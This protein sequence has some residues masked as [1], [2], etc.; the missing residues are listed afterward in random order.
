MS[1]EKT[2]SLAEALTGLSQNRIQALSL[3]QIKTINKTPKVLSSCE[4]HARSIT[5]LAVLPNDQVVSGS[6]DKTLKVW[7]PVTGR[8]LAT[9][10]GHT[11]WVKC[12]AVL[13]NGQVVS[14]SSDNTLKVWDPNTGVCL[15][16]LKGH[17]ESVSCIGI[18]PNGQVVSGSDDGTL[19]IWEPNTG[20]CLTTLKGHTSSVQQIAISPNGQVVSG[21]DDGTLK[22]WEPLT[23]DRV[24]ELKA[25]T[26]TTER[27]SVSCVAVLPTGQI[28]GCLYD[29]PRSE[30]WVFESAMKFVQAKK[31]PKEFPKPHTLRVW[32]PLT[33]NCITK[34]IEH[35]VFCI[36]ILPTGQIVTGSGANIQIW[37]SSTGTC[38]TTLSGHT[39]NVRCIGILPNGQVVSGSED[40]TSKVWDLTTGTCLTTLTRHTKA[41]S[42][43]II[44]P[45]GQVVSGFGDGSLKIWEPF[46]LSLSADEQP[47]LFQAVGENLSLHTLDCSDFALSPAGIQSLTKAIAKHPTLRT[48]HL[49][50]CGLTDK[51]AEGLFEALEQSENGIQQVSL[52]GNALS[53]SRIHQLQ[54]RL[55]QK[56]TTYLNPQKLVLS[57]TNLTELHFHQ[58]DN[59]TL[60][61]FQQTTLPSQIFTE[62]FVNFYQKVK[63]KE[64]ALPLYNA[65]NSALKT[66]RATQQNDTAHNTPNSFR[67]HLA[68]MGNTVQTL[69][70]NPN[71]KTS[72][73]QAAT[74]YI[75][76]TVKETQ[77]ELQQLL[78]V[79]PSNSLMDAIKD[80]QKPIEGAVNT[81]TELGQAFKRP[82]ELT[83]WIPFMD[84]LTGTIQAVKQGFDA[85]AKIDSNTISKTAQTLFTQ[86]TH[87]NGE[88]LKQHHTLNEMAV[89]IYEGTRTG[90]GSQAL[91]EKQ[92]GFV[93]AAQAA[94]KIQT[95]F[96]GVINTIGVGFECLSKLAGF[97]GHHQFARE[98]ATV[99]R[100]ATSIS[101]MAVN[102]LSSITAGFATGSVLG[103]VGSIIGG[104]VGGVTAL[105]S[106]ICSFFSSGPNPHEV[107]QNMIAELSKQLNQVRQEMH[108][109]FDHLEKMLTTL[110]GQMHQ[111]FDRIEMQIGYLY[112]GILGQFANMGHQLK[113]IGT[114]TNIIKTLSEEIQV[115]LK[116]ISQEIDKV[117]LQQF[118]HDF[119]NSVLKFKGSR[120]EENDFLV[121]CR[122]ATDY[123]QNAFFAGEPTALLNL[124]EEGVS[125]LLGPLRRKPVEY[126]MN[127]LFCYA[128][129]YLGLNSQLTSLVNPQIWSNGVLA[130]VEFYYRKPDIQFEKE[131]YKNGL[132][133]V[134]LAGEHICQG[135]MELKVN[136]GVFRQLFTQYRQILLSI[137]QYIDAHPDSRPLK[138]LFMDQTAQLHW[139]DLRS[140]FGSYC[141]EK[142]YIMD[143]TP[144][145]DLN[146]AIATTQMCLEPM[147]N[148]SDQARRRE[149]EKRLNASVFRLLHE[150]LQR[151][152]MTPLTEQQIRAI[153]ALQKSLGEEAKQK[154][155]FKTLLQQLDFHYYLLTGF[156]SLAFRKAYVEDPS[157][158]VLVKEKLWDSGS[159]LRYLENGSALQREFVHLVIDKEAL[160]AVDQLEAL[161]M[162]HIGMAQRAKE[163]NN[164]KTDYPL[165]EE[166]TSELQ[167]LQKVV[168]PK[169]VA[170]KAIL[171]EIRVTASDELKKVV[172]QLVKEGYDFKI[173]RPNLGEIVIKFTSEN[174]V[175]DS[176]EVVRTRLSNLFSL[177]KTDLTNKGLSGYTARADWKG[178]VLKLSC[179][180]IYVMNQIGALLQ[181]AGM[182]Y[183]V[184]PVIPSV[185]SCGPTKVNKPEIENSEVPSNECKMQ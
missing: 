87:I 77:G 104:I 50:Y 171:P 91:L 107:T 58:S 38:L 55:S 51:N 155:M 78:K 148:V 67:F 146:L 31:E 139:E 71:L 116:Q 61:C 142:G 12:L 150:P 179:S 3:S 81:L 88:A 102:A 22:I 19:K 162:Q 121:I 115:G 183:W 180:E 21:S 32:D 126:H 147:L 90:L 172:E 9:L 101:T 100:I 26:N 27:Q 75:E 156:I 15:T 6:S 36:A 128:K 54:K 133:E 165:L 8:C 93:K 69:V 117:R 136:D 70:K 14:G 25:H 63:G 152:Q 123:A 125:D 175:V 177:V 40:N 154:G 49:N 20:T 37:D 72:W 160:K 95:Q 10:T 84:S 105:G 2:Y 11:R 34:S 134:A 149:M 1:R 96:T 145:I 167:L 108:Q 52:V 138:S 56:H 41:V 23:G 82:G 141:M 28:V 83:S 13:P 122:Y 62:G 89:S 99:G 65:V 112:E 86:L 106:W 48:L 130:L 170:K 33:G 59:K 98:I 132:K 111:R 80:L 57:A 74:D 185:F 73:V 97:C 135:I 119:N 47:K 174:E 92:Q 143:N 178:G 113:E 29:N 44:L 24:V 120:L 157:L 129:K 17:T 159:I 30:M 45:N 94:E 109:R 39:G 144:S 53:T 85:I 158:S 140:T 127:S 46:M 114:A 118:N 7:D 18:L 35:I 169:P 173:Q 131:V 181:D 110:H 5:C 166:L 68:V 43:L 64:N 182:H 184:Q 42:H 151:H 76:T 163:S 103:P 16:T 164:L 66:Y 137:I 176:N 60:S 124:N 168:L 161:L 4:E 79:V 153:L